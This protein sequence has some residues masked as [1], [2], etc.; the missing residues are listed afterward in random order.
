MIACSLSHPSVPSARSILPCS[1][2]SLHCF[3]PSFHPLPYGGGGGAP[4]WGKGEKM[5]RGLAVKASLF[6]WHRFQTRPSTFHLA[7]NYFKT[8]HQRSRSGRP[9]KQN[10]NS[11]VC[12]LTACANNGASKIFELKLE[13][14][15]S[16]WCLDVLTPLCTVLFIFDIIKLSADLFTRDASTFL[17]L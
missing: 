10:L 12:S 3:P 2:P 17:M 8:P 9:L 6:Q 13:L 1:L 5:P 7:S 15:Q 4:F 11:H 16:S 14:M